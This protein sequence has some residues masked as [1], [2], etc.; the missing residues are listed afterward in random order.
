M[1]VLHKLLGN[2]ETGKY[3]LVVT[4]QKKA[5]LVLK[6]ARLQHEHVRN[7]GWDLFH[8]I[9]GLVGHG[10]SKYALAQQLQQVVSVAAILH[11]PRNLLNFVRAD[12]SGTKGDFFGTSHHESL[13]LLDGLDVH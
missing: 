7:C 11:H 12:V 9:H 1:I 2:P 10:H 13:P 6:D 4:F 5:A 8:C 3:S